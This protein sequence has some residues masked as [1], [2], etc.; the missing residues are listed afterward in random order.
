VTNFVEPKA[1]S[2]SSIVLNLL[3]SKGWS[4]IFRRAL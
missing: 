1:N 4:G 2:S 3:I